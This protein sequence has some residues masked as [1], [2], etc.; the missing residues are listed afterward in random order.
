MLEI[1][2]RA[3]VAS[4]PGRPLTLMVIWSVFVVVAL[5]MLG[6]SSP[7]V[8][9]SVVIGSA[10]V[11]FVVLG[12]RFRAA[13]IVPA[14]W[15][16]DRRDL[17]VVGGLFAA[18]VGLFKLAFG[19]FGV[20]SVAGLFLSFGTALT[21]GVAVPV[22][23]TV[24]VRRRSLSAIGVGLHNWKPTVALG[25]VFAATQFGLTLWG[26]ELPQPVDWVPLLVMSLA[27]GIFESIF[28][29]GFV[30]GVLEQSFGV[31]P[32]VLG[33]A[34][35]Y[36]L[37][38][39]GYGMGAREIG[40][41]VGLGVTYAV[42]YRLTTNVLIMWPLFTPIGGFFNML[43]NGDIEMPWIAILGFVDVIGL[44]VGA[45]VLTR[46]IARKRRAREVEAAPI[47]AK[48]AA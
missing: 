28:F 38:H 46:R 4:K 47:T 6:V 8:Y 27:V 33:G 23:Y 13:G 3:R 20:D 40:F 15:H 25:L 45:F 39:V 30:Q 14:R 48:D 18:C 22:F 7:V 17:I 5:L 24:L 43:E 21:L 12:G 34:V 44:M 29:R 41:L 37:Y 36:G 19:V 11:L 9:P 32:S 35:L 2:Q 31:G 10:V 26:Y 1:A 42:A 16:A